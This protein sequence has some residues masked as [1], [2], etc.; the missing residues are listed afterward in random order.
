MLHYLALIVLVFVCLMLSVF[1]FG[2]V[3]LYILN[4]EENMIAASFAALLAVICAILT[5]FLLLAVTTSIWK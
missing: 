2:R 3:F 1:I 5:V 4:T